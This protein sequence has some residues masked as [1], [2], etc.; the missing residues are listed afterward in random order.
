[1][2]RANFLWQCFSTLL[3]NPE[4]QF[5]SETVMPEEPDQPSDLDATILTQRSPVSRPGNLTPDLPL[6]E[7]LSAQLPAGAYHVQSFIGQ[8]G[9]GAVYKALQTR[10]QRTVAIKIMRRGQDKELGFEQRFQREAL[11]LAKLSHPNIV[12]VIDC[13]EAGPDFLYIVMEFVDGADLMDVIRTGRM[14]QE[15]A[16]LLLPQICDAL[17][18]AHDHGIVHR[19]IK[20]S[21][22]MLT[23]DGRIK[24][25]DFGLAKR[26]D[27]E[28]SLV[29]RT[30]TSMGTPDYAAPEQ[31]DPEATVDH[32]ADIYALGAMIYQM[33]TGQ[34]PRGVW[35]P[36][37]QRSEC[38]PQW[39]DI[40]GRA[41]QSDPKDR[42]QQ[43]SEVRS[44]LSD[45][46]L[47]R[48]EGAV[49]SIRTSGG[50]ASEAK[51]SHR[52]PARTRLIA[53]FVAVGILGTS[54]FLF[55]KG[56]GSASSR[57][58]AVQAVFSAADK[59]N[60]FI[61]SLG[62]KFVP[63]PINGGP[64]DGKRVLFSVWETRV[65]DYEVFAKETKVAWPK[66]DFE[67]GGAHPAVMVSWHDATAFCTWLT[68]RERKSGSLP[69]TEIYRLPSDH[70]WS[71]A[72]GIGEREDPA[73]TPQE[74]HHKIA[75]TYY[76]GKGW[77]PPQ[78][79]GNFGGQENADEP[80]GAITQNWILADYRDGYART[81]PVGSFPANPLGLRDLGGNVYEWCEDWANANSTHRVKRDT[82]W[83]W[84]GSTILLASTRN[85]NN[86]AER[87]TGNGFRIV[88][89]QV[90]RDS[91]ATSA[92]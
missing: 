8:G 16:L 10:L 77:P 50:P 90:S 3:H 47:K 14:T 82:S 11:A 48:E 4:R 1:M 87:S 32:R 18:F 79:I 2:A 25:A 51:K 61:N 40:V 6:P 33:I 71:C 54:A 68:E 39:D 53:A 23:R 35:K 72:A 58:A 57:G 55:Q 73:K 64:T 69:A 56:K 52:G 92:K 20:P 26:L 21:N 78:G 27:V 42:Y 62:M 36:P 46:K 70:E 44:D 89:A 63:V 34:L 74:K 9:M 7:E 83:G 38:A 22:V 67:Q 66:P 81:A 30:G 31:F 29:T 65:Q 19:D 59:E 15:M 5:S 80:K 49:T 60:P 12:S 17:Q 41:M 84:A 45:I 24:M 76:W 75:D 37:S 85:Y 28:N 91:T 43:A 86:P 88:L 13:G